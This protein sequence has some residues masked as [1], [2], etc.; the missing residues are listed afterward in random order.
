MFN[1]RLVSGSWVGDGSS[2][3]GLGGGL[4]AV[5]ILNND[6][7]SA[8]YSKEVFGVVRDHVTTVSTVIG[9]NANLYIVRPSVRCA[10][11]YVASVAY[12]AYAWAYPSG[13]TSVSI[14][15]SVSTVAGVSVATVVSGLIANVIC[16]CC[17][18]SNVLL[19]VV[20]ST[21]LTIIVSPDPLYCFKIIFNSCGVTVLSEEYPV[22]CPINCNVLSAIF[23]LMYI[24]I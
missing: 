17:K 1:W 8:W 22:A 23:I 10:G 21:D 5:I 14:G 19:R 2:T 16:I 24:Y 20:V 15:T 6:V 11:V 18:T 12:S 13:G 3:V 4:N 9:V 7:Y